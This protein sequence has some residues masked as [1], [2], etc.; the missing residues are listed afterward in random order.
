MSAER[1]EKSFEKRYRI[2]N[3]EA[4]L[5]A[6]FTR[7]ANRFLKEYRAAFGSGDVPDDIN[8]V[9]E[10]IRA[11]REV[12]DVDYT[13]NYD[14]AWYGGDYRHYDS[15]KRTDEVQ[16]GTCYDKDEYDNDV[17]FVRWYFYSVTVF[18]K[19]IAGETKTTTDPTEHYKWS[20][21]KRGKY[22]YFCTH[23]PPSG[24][25]IPAGY[26]SFEQYARYSR[27]CGEA[28]YN[29]PP[30]QSTLDEWGLI[31]DPEW[32]RTREHYTQDLLA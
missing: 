15:Y 2:P 25:C 16:Y 8:A 21:Q 12:E 10:A 3:T 19:T 6:I 22:R 13:E 26:A 9:A 24:G 17:Y 5:K 4:A 7:A 11:G 29:E 32:E 1:T 18:K 30:E 31:P 28:T 14:G 20:F 27:Y 23:R